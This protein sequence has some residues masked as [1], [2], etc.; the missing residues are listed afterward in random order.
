[1]VQ[2]ILVT[3]ASGFV[4]THIIR[5]FLE[6]GYNVRATVRSQRSADGV[7]ASHPG[8]EEKISFAIVPD[9]AAAGALDEAVKGVDGVIHTASP[10]IL[11]AKDFEKELYT[12]SLDGT[13]NALKSVKK[14]AP[15]VKRVVITSS[16]ASVVDPPKGTRPGY[17]YTEADWNSDTKEVV[18]EPVRAYLLSKKLAEKA[19]FEFVETEKPNFSITTMAPPMVY[20]PV[21]HQVASIDKLNTSSQDIHRL[22]D[23]SEKEVPP[24]SF[25]GY[26]DVRDLALAHLR[27]YEKP[28]AANQ[29]YII[30]Y[31]SYTYEQFVGLIRVNFPAL[32]ATTP[33]ADANVP[34]P[35]NVYRIDN[36]KSRHELGIEYRPFKDTV[37]DTVQSILDLKKKLGAN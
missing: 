12:P 18:T 33:V 36:S 35:D 10:F 17:T 37:V 3:G 5:T 7:L 34:F 14:N 15:N 11:G 23:G 1:M 4:A 19:A 24:T 9:I 21:L 8:Y 31:G 28:E 6:A 26:V 32:V 2:T 20:G 27:G 29:R 25:Y 16:F 22:F 13:V 30:T